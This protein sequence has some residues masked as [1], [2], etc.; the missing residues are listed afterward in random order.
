[1]TIKVEDPK[2][3]STRHLGSSFKI[4]DEIYQFKSFSRERVKVLLSLDV[5]SVD[6]T[7]PNVHRTDKDFALAWRRDYGR[8]RVFYTALGHRDEVWQD[9]RF[10]RML[11]G[12]IRWV[13]KS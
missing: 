12:A 11:I 6:L 7:K 5:S 9:E 13:T 2:D 3:P 1:V 10:Q 8:G 4:T